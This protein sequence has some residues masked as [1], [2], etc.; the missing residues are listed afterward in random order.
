MQLVSIG[1]GH[2]LAPAPAASFLRARAAGCPL[3]ITSSFRDPA[4]QAAMRAEYDVELADFRAGRRATKPT[5]VAQVKDSEHVT[6]NALD[7]QDPAIAWMRAHPDYGFVFTDPTE[8]WHVAYRPALDRHAGEPAPSAPPAP[9]TPTDVLELMK[10]DLW[11]RCN[12]L[13]AKTGEVVIVRPDGTVGAVTAAAYDTMTNLG[14]RARVEVK[15]CQQLD[16]VPFWAL[17]R[18]LGYPG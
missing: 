16:P 2:Q 1:A 13:R 5:F 7:L 8:R 3:A 4:R 12:I 10:M 18:M 17:V 6:G 11:D 14:V 15:D 9:L